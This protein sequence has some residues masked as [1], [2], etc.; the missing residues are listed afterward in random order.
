MWGRTRGTDDGMASSWWQRLVD[1]RVDEKRALGWAF[2]YVF[3]LFV[4]YYVLRPIRDELGVTGGVR[5]LPWLFTGTLVAM[6]VL[7]PLFSHLVRL[8]SRRRFIAIAYRFFI[9]N[10]LLFMVA[11][12]WTTPEQQVWVGRALFIWT[13]V[14]NLF[15]V[16][17]FWSL[18]VDIFDARQGKRLFGLLAAG[19]TAGGMVGSGVTATLVMLMDKH[20]LLLVA[21]LLLEV[22][23][24]ASARLCA[25]QA[26]QSGTDAQQGA[27]ASDGAPV[28]A[29][30]SVMV[31]S[32]RKS[33]LSA[34]GVA[35]GGAVQ[36]RV[37][38]S[39]L[40]D[41]ADIR[42]SGSRE[43]DRSGLGGGVFAGMTHT[44]R[45]P[46]LLGISAI[47]LL[48]TITSTFLYFQQAEI[49]SVQFP[50][51]AE[52]TAF[53]AQID[54]WVNALTLLFQVFVTGALTRWLGVMVVLCILPALS[55]LG[56]GLLWAWPTVAVFVM[57]QVA[58][59]VA[60]FAFNK[61]TREVLFTHVAREDRYKAKNFI[62]TVVYRSGD[63]IGSWGYAALMAAGLGM[64]GISLVGVPLSL[65]W[66]GLA[67]WLG[68]QQRQA[69]GGLRG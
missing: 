12:G 36:G 26:R 19:A 69:D 29:D 13:S 68:V 54:L 28:A 41:E 14:F 42:S 57:V 3:A 40:R 22:A 59:R 4:A 35:G 32:G 49:A 53:F 44:L 61:P 60:N 2:L 62:D 20:W 16:S 15:V 39:A 11:L 50:D 37:G 10:L 67:A 48:Y 17:V 5:N 6:L 9:V 45:S 46:Y 51:R 23:V 43:S 18:M 27:V 56:F 34:A 31:D 8:W 33:E 21:A 24:F 30:A 66:L 55:M 1:V 7:N 47:I 63:Q 65:L 38:N 52:R 64:S 25:W 58:R